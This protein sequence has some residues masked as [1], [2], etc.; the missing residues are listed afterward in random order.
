MLKKLEWMAVLIGALTLTPPA[1]A[2]AQ[3][4]N[5]AS[6]IINKPG[7]TTVNGVKAKNRSDSAVQGGK[8]IRLPIVKANNLWDV[9]V[10]TAIDKPIKAGDN[11]ILAFWARL[12]KSPDGATTTI[13]KNAAIQLASPPWS[14]VANGQ[15]TVG[16]NWELHEIKGKADKDYGA[17]SVGV[18]IQLGDASRTMDFGPV[19]VLNMGQ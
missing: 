2:A 7:S 5:I 3:D 10:N 15:V 16:P 18:T 14:S 4:D 12:E 19:F 13:I 9:S 17:G 1:A 8:A 6:K 11:L